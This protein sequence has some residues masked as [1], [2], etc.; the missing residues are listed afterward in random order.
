MIMEAKMNWKVFLM[1]MAIV[2]ISMGCLCCCGPSGGGG[3]SGYDY[4]YDMY[5]QTPAEGIQTDTQ[6]EKTNL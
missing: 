4:D 5:Y 1:V 3:Y 6:I 2:V